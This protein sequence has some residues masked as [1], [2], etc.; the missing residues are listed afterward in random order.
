MMHKIAVEWN[1]V[2]RD[3]KYSVEDDNNGFVYGVEYYETEGLQTGSPANVVWFDTEEKRDK[4]MCK[5]E[6]KQWVSRTPEQAMKDVREAIKWASKHTNEYGHP[7]ATYTVLYSDGV[8]HRAGIQT[9]K[10][11]VY[12]AFKNL[13]ESLDNAMSDKYIPAYVESGHVE[14]VVKSFNF[15]VKVSVKRNEVRKADN[16]AKI[17]KVAA[18]RK[19]VFSNE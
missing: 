3:N 15:G 12:E 9:V 1:D 6:D 18:F 16:Q 2:K 7:R 8:N 19:E 11:Y 4:E 10:W 17:D 14:C 5:A 13:Q